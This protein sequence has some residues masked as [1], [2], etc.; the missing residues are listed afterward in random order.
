MILA[1][2]ALADGFASLSLEVDAGGVEEDQLEFSEQIEPVGEQPLLDQILGT[3]R[4]EWCLVRLFRA[5]QLLTEPGHG[6]VEMVELQS[7][8]SFNLIILLPLVGGAITARVE[9]TMKNCEEDG[10]LDG[11]LI[12]AAL[13][14]LTD[15]M[16][17]AGLLPEPLEDQSRTN[18]S[19][20]VGREFPLSM[21]CQ[22]QDRLGQAGTRDEQSLELSA[23]LEFIKPSQGSDDP[24]P[25]ATTLPAVL[26]DLEI[27]P[28]P[29]GLGAEE[30]GI[31]LLRT[32]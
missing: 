31:L 2:A 9:E 14:E 27:G 30:H 21:V 15:H 10:P 22:D 8:T 23:S 25:G 11:E 5:G 18:A 6:P 3:S 19:A 17:T 12:V 26:H 32:P 16:L 4:S 24:L 7:L 28:W 29:R 1:V 13:E 20:G